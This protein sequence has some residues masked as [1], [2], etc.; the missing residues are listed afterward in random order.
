MDG[1]IDSQRREFAD[2]PDE[3]SPIPFWFWNDAIDEAEIERQI[4]D[5]RSKGVAGFVIHPRMGLPREIPYLSDRF[6]GLVRSAV[7]IAAGLGMRV[8]LYDE[9]MYPSGSAHG[10]V[11]RRRPELA[12]HSLRMAAQP[13]GETRETTDG[14]VEGPALSPGERIAAA[15]GARGN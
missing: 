9:A 6:M 14:P 8:V 2:P 15:F 11:A 5:F 12:A 7:E 4:R 10:E 3:F 1:S 13:M